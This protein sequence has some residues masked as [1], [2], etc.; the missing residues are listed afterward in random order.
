[1]KALYRKAA[2][3]IGAD[4]AR[5]IITPDPFCFS[6]NEADLALVPD[7]EYSDVVLR[8]QEAVQRD[9]TRCAVRN[10]QFTDVVVNAL[11]QQR[12]CLEVVD[13]GTDRI[14]RCNRSRGILVVQKLECSLQVSQ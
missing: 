1:M 3:G 8:H 11:P 14:C 12:V 13:R 9:V 10:H 2:A 5:E 4:I 6:R 7:G